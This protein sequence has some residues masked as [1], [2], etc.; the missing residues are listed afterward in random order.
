MRTGPTN[1]YL[2]TLIRDLKRHCVKEKVELWGA[3]AKDLSVAARRRRAVNLNR[4][5][6]YAHDNETV[7]VPGKVLGVGEITKNISVC[8]FDFSSSAKAKIKNTVDFYDLMKNNPK[9]K[10]IR[11]IG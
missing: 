6:K 1:V 9:G 11:I 3:L 8:A 5:N 2:K 4:I 7:V 10:N